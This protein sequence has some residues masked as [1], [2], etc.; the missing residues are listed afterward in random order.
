MTKTGMAVLDNLRI[1]EVHGQ[2]VVLDSGLAA[3]ALI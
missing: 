2:A 3:L 1:L